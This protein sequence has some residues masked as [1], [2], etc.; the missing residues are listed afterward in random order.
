MKLNH[1]KKRNTAFLYEVLISELTKSSLNNRQELQETIVKVL[2]EYFS[3]GK[4]LAEELKLYKEF[5]NL[6]GY[7]KEIISKIISEAL[8]TREKLNNKDIFNEQ[9]KLIGAINKLIGKHSF[10]NFVPNYK[11]LAT[12][13]QIF[14]EKTPIKS[15]VI[16]EN[17]LI[18]SIVNDSKPAV[19]ENM[20]KVSKAVYKIF[21]NKFNKKYTNLNEGQKTLLKLYI[22]SVRDGGLELKSYINE[23][24]NEVKETINSYI[25]EADA[26]GM[27]NALEEVKKEIASFKGQ[28]ISEEILKKLLSMQSLKEEIKNG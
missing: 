21:T 7:N 19:T 11:N 22:E 1:N 12:I 17:N 27:R 16:L 2:K 25:A 15:R 28:Y 18:Q 24:L 26:E 8:K 14:N 20:E 23:E 13:Y 9:T 3:K 5:E 10:E 4:I 6:Q